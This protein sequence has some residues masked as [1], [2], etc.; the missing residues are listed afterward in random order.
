MPLLLRRILMIVSLIGSMPVLSADALSASIPML[1][2][3]SALTLDQAVAKVRRASGGK[4]IG[5]DTIEQ[6]GSTAYR[7]K[8]VFPDGKV[9]VYFVDPATGEI[10]N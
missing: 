2:Q 3:A 8:V 4:V 10:Q 5:A 1:A 7:I 6:D 9:R